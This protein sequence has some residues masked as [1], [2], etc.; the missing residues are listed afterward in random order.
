MTE[1]YLQVFSNNPQQ[2]I[3]EQI[4]EP[5][6][7]VGIFWHRLGTPTDDFDSGTVEEYEIAKNRFQDDSN[8]VRIMIYF[9]S[10]A[11]TSLSSIDPK[12]YDKLVT[13]KSKLSDDG[14]LYTEI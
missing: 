7:F 13:F 6:L 12:Q 5:D 2:V 4:G 3:N 10:S 11:P 9:K 1:I 14:C 8:N